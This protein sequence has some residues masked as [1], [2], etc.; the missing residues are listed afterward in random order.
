MYLASTEL[1]VGTKG[2]QLIPGNPVV[3]GLYKRSKHHLLTKE[4][5]LGLVSHLEDQKE[6]IVVVVCSHA[7]SLRT[8][9]ST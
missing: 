9:N 6:D 3:R 4:K 8:I 7:F 2:H 5:V 1:Y